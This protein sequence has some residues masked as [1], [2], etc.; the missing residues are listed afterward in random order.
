MMLRDATGRGSDARSR[1]ESGAAL[2]DDASSG[3]TGAK[4]LSR[5]G[6]AGILVVKSGY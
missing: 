6:V 2:P 4:R 5:A 1:L 3:P